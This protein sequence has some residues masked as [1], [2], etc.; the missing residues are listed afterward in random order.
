ML[1][2]ACMLGG[3]TVA[4]PIQSVNR[5]GLSCDKDR[6]HTA[7]APGWPMTSPEQTPGSDDSLN[8]QV[9]EICDRFEAA[10]KSGSAPRIEDYLEQLPG[11]TDGSMLLALVKLD[12]EYRAQNGESPT[13]DEYAERFPEHAALIRD[14][15]NHLLQT[16]LKEQHAAPIPATLAEPPA[17]PTDEVSS[18]QIGPYKILQPIGHGGM[19]QVFMAEQHEPVRR[20]VALKIIK[21]DTPSK[22]I[23]GR[24]EAE[25]QALA[26]MDHQNIARVLDAGITAD[27]RPYF[28]MELVKGIPITEYCDQNRLTPDARLELFVQTCRAIQHAHQK[29]II[30]RDL[31]PSNVLVTLYDGKP[32][33]KVIDF[34]LAKALQDT[35][36][37]TNRTLFTQ[38]GQVVGTLAYMSP[39]QAEMNALDVDTRTDVYSLGV[40]LYELLTG[41][42]PIDRERIRNEAF[43]RILQLIRE[44]ETPRPSSRLSDS[45]DAITGIS[46]QRHTE[47]RRL[48][49]ILKGELDWIAVKALEKDRGRR[50]DG[51][52]ALADDVQRYLDDEAVEAR[53]P[54]FGYQLQKAFRKHRARFITGA[55]VAGILVAALIV[56]GAM[57]LRARSAETRAVA[58]AIR[59][60]DEAD[61]AKSAEL[62]AKEEAAK[63]R[64][65][66]AKL[67]QNLTF[68]EKNTYNWDMLQVQRNWE[69]GNLKY[70]LEL[71]D[72]YRN[73]DDLKGFEW[74]YWERR[75]IL[76]LSIKGFTHGVASV[77]FSPDGKR[78]VSGGG[79]YNGREPG[80]VKIWDA[81]TG[82]EML[83]L[84]GHSAW[85]WS[86]NF[87]PDGKWIVSGGGDQTV[88]LWD[89]TTGQE[90]LTLQGHMGPLWSVRF[91]PDGTQVVSCSS[92]NTARVWDAK[93]GHETL[94]FKGHSNRVRSASY[95]PDGKRIVSVCDGGTMRFWDAAT[96]QETLTLQ[97]QNGA[98]YSVDFSPDGT[99]VVSGGNDKTV[100]VWNAETGHQKRVLR[101]HTNPIFRVKFSRDGKRIVSGSDDHTVKLW[102]AETGQEMLTL[103]GHSALVH[104]VGFSP[105]GKRIV[106]GSGDKTVKIWDADFDPE[107]LALKGHKDDVQSVSFS[108]DG[109]L[110]VSGSWDDTVKLWDAETGQE[111]F[112]LRGHTGDVQSVGFSPDGKR[113]ISGS[114]DKTLKLWDAA[115]GQEMLTLKGH[116]EP[117]ENVRF[118][119]EGKRIISSSMDKTV[120][121][122]DAATGEETLTLKGHSE[123]VFCVGFSPDAKRIVSG[124]SD[125][126]VKV[127]DAATGQETLTLTGH[128]GAVWSVNFS[129]DGKRIVSG[130]GN[131]DNTVKVWDAES[132]QGTLTL[133]G[134]SKGIRRVSFSPDGKRIVSGS[135]D[136]T[137]KVWDAETGQQTLTLNGHS[138]VVKSVSFSP[139]G[140]R[141]ISSSRDE[142]VKVWDARPWSAERR[143]ARHLAGVISQAT[144]VVHAAR[145][146]EF[147]KDGVA[148]RIRANQR[149]TEE[150]RQKALQ[151]VDV[152]SGPT[153]QELNAMSWNTVQSADATRTEYEKA[154]RQIRAA[155]ESEPEKG[156]YVNTLGVAQYRV[157]DYQAAL[158]TL[159]RSEQLNNEA[160]GGS[161]PPDLVFLA[162]AN[163]QLGNT[164]EAKQQ[165]QLLRQL[166]L[167]PR[168]SKDAELQSFLQEAE[169]LIESEPP[170]EA[171]REMLTLN[172]HTGSVISV[173]YSPDGKRIVS[174]S[175]EDTVR[176]W[177]AETGEEMLTLKGHTDEVESVSFS[178]DGKRVVS[179]GRDDT[180][181]LWDA[182]TGQEMFTLKGHSGDVWTVSFSPDGKR[183]VSGSGGPG[184]PGEIRVWDAETGQETFAFKGH[185]VNV[186]CVRFSSDGKQVVSCSQDKTVKLWDAET[187]EET[188]TLNGHTGSVISVSYSPDGKRVV[189]GSRDKTVKVWDAE[190]GQELLTLKG[191][192]GHVMSV[193]FSPDG[194]RV[195]SGSLDSTVKLWNTETGQ[196]TLTFTGH[197]GAVRNVNFSPDGK[198]IVSGSD[199]WTLKVWDAR[200]WT[201]ELPA[202]PETKAADPATPA[203]PAATPDPSPD[204]TPPA[205]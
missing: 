48:S 169:A 72:R 15:L 193:D 29:G 155:V 56:T 92:D 50:Y 152:T 22:E 6:H 176:L 63:A 172:G 142:T 183:I 12:V 28:A 181:K 5:S 108:P 188:L 9:D 154:L 124:S 14:K 115:T 194:E 130:G 131:S 173:S 145:Q 191:H 74:H 35:I 107:P 198:R 77:S 75:N 166:I 153:A 135:W 182:E 98:L 121:L 180:L 175:D 1:S 8:R 148:K 96:G 151:L 16:T 46:E 30:H 78:I 167:E 7:I 70:V 11:E 119:P 201:A 31:K 39:E 61:K 52:A 196:E 66:E 171:D 157:G 200:P 165:L 204:A 202:P 134:H 186:N 144:V 57:W 120:K 113:I 55:A 68:V 26:M 179:G 43:D 177:D 117:I 65:A 86:V 161:S 10:W 102:D 4:E 143:A 76:L 112:T 91:S 101:G 140:K 127:W 109:K 170:A 23:L 33:A 150:V 58:E 3:V 162:M 205:K 190:T 38:Y 147:R 185:S 79:L 122:W 53:P 89:A 163:Q 47:P 59:A 189:S 71:L 103:N 83:A 82:R 174:C 160:F 25:R 104:G 110:I 13:A 87:S 94:T 27:G 114:D 24:F 116:A 20:R 125:R 123:R 49:L 2:V 100:K 81:D 164:D 192:V 137:V 187:G 168:W 51:P 156:Y 149:I 67:R 141:I 32:V 159:T 17:K 45:G 95:S 203:Q 62:H 84:E 128:S 106:S 197:T 80:V 195:V 118:S 60:N 73:R 126:T 34:G 90:T 184:Q 146:E 132:G 105:D 139:D 158:T 54:S 42:T 136:N 21:T 133:Y 111:M 64:G 178:P 88:K 18:R 99:Q 129:P 69:D 36:Q 85:V 44:E 199:D 93:T 37:L 41:S 138:D 40:I 19:G 97:G